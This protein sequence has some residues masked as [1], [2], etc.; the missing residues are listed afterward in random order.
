MSTITAATA[1]V[2]ELGNVRAIVAVAALSGIWIVRDCRAQSVPVV[3]RAEVVRLGGL[4][5]PARP[6]SSVRP[7]AAI[8]DSF[9]DL[10]ACGR[11]AM[12][13][14]EMLDELTAA[15]ARWANRRPRRLRYR[16]AIGGSMIAGPSIEIEMV[17]D[18]VA[19]ARMKRGHAA[20]IPSPTWLFARA[21]QAIRGDSDRV[22]ISYDRTYGLPILID[23]DP[24]ACMTD[25]AMYIVV[26]RLSR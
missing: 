14:S 7:P 2:P 24:K 11:D 17:R 12:S 6:A 18:S 23:D 25:D 22:S 5:A 10:I 15:R 19:S 1:R 9:D 3:P 16:V 4:S 20:E 8:G 21:E 26:D 13:H